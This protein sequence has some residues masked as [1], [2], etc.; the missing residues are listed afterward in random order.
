L[1]LYQ[2]ID[3]G[4]PRLIEEGIRHTPILGNDHAPITRAPRAPAHG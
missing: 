4:Q 3:R 2:V 1:P